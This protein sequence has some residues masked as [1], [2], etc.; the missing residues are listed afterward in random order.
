MLFYTVGQSRVFLAM[1]YAGLIVGACYDFSCGARRVLQAGRLLTAV[2]D[3]AFALAAALLIGLTLWRANFAHLR[4]Y[5]LLG[6]A[7]GAVL[8]GFTLGPLL[9]GAGRGVLRTGTRL[10]Q[11]LNARTAI[12]KFFQ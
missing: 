1:L 9:R 2:V 3:L 10:L 11:W 5:A 8:Y 12:K 4:L 7:C 6:A